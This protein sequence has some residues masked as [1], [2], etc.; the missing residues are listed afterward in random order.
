MGNQLTPPKLTIGRPEPE[1]LLAQ[2]GKIIWFTGLSGPENC[3]I[4]I[5][6]EM[7]LY[8]QGKHT[9]LLDG[10][11]VR[12]DLSCDLNFG[13]TDRTENVSRIA[14]VA[15]LMMDAGLIVIYAFMPPF[16][17]KRQQARTLAGD[18]RFVDIYS[19]PR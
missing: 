11:I 6:L 7:A 3:S 1:A 15:K 19:T 4:A 5:A 18:C 13:D 9:F 14:H 2:M 16:Q 12:K 10:D 17:K 8:Q